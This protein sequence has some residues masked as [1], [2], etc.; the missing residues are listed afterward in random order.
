MTVEVK[1][2]SVTDLVNAARAD[3]SKI[4]PAPPTTARS[5]DDLATVEIPALSSLGPRILLMDAAEAVIADRG[6]RHTT[7]R[8]VA[9]FAGVSVD[10]FHAH[11]ADMRALLVAL[12]ER[13]SEQAM[14]LIDEATRP[15]RW[16]VA[17]GGS[18]AVEYAV[19]GVVEMMLGRAALVR[20]IFDD[21]PLIDELRRVGAHLTLQLTRLLDGVG[22]RDVGFAVLSALAIAHHAATVGPEWS[23]LELDRD[24]LAKRAANMAVA[25]LEG[26]RAR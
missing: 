3:S 24:D 2:L 16:D 15:A 1:A 25:Y 12:C 4:P 21:R 23:G 22:A 5:L 18:I 7:I 8:E 11:F 14:N 17:E 9:S 6:Y 19:R 20:A 13:F 10:V 26:C